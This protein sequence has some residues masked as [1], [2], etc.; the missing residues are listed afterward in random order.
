MWVEKMRGGHKLMLRQNVRGRIWMLN[1]KAKMDGER[2]NVMENDDDHG[3][4]EKER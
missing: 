2:V 4:E 3:R 1:L